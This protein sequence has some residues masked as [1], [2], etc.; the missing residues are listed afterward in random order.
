MRCASRCGTHR[1]PSGESSPFEM[2]IVH[3]G[4][5]D[6]PQPH[7]FLPEPE[8]PL[9]ACFFAMDPPNP[10]GDATL[11]ALGAAAE[12]TRL[13]AEIVDTPPEQMNTDTFRCGSGH[14]R[15]FRRRIT[16]Q[17][18]LTSRPPR[19]S[20]GGRHTPVASWPSPRQHMS[21][22]KLTQD[23]ASSQLSHSA[24]APPPAPVS[25]IAKAVAQS[26]G[27]TVV[28]SEVVGED[29]ATQGFGCV[30]HRREETLV[31]AA[32]FL[33]PRSYTF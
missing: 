21:L 13:A 17:S 18:P 1:R 10:A 30:S 14:S 28:Y 15:P 4:P 31:G 22:P 11:A 7:S 16:C 32:F 25:A 26:L 33:P 3:Q 2:H 5:G 12:G 6:A 20:S 9:S 27:E 23:A 24:S 29:L 8:F 19:L